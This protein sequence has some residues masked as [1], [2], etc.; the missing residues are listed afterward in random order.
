V[1]VLSARPRD[2]GPVSKRKTP[3]EPYTAQQIR[4]RRTNLGFSQ[5]RLAYAL[6]VTKAAV[7]HWERGEAEPSLKKLMALAIALDC[8]VAGTR[9]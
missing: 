1:L 3:S 7:Q 9:W 8:E 2:C 5:E 6:G 4:Q